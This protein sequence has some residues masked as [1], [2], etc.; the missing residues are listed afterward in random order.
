[1]LN[2]SRSL[3]CKTLQFIMLLGLI[4]NVVAITMVSSDTNNASLCIINEDKE[5]ECFEN[6]QKCL[7]SESKHAECYN[8]ENAQN[9]LDEEGIKKKI[10]K[11]DNK[12]V[13][14]L[15]SRQKVN[16]QDGSKERIS[17]RVL[18]E[19]DSSWD[20]ADNTQKEKGIKSVKINK[21]AVVS[22]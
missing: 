12:C 7:L 22:F 2:C 19:D 15:V 9:V 14:Y 5:D 21:K 6:W 16:E 17:L 20:I 10:C 8:L 18:K 1:M 3:I 13:A 11:D 4:Q